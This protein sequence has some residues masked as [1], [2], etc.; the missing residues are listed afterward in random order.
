[1]LSRSSVVEALRAAAMTEWRKGTEESRMVSWR[2]SI[3]MALSGLVVSMVSPGSFPLPGL[4][5]GMA[6]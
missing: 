4:L 2:S 3:R 5:A 6:S 1:M